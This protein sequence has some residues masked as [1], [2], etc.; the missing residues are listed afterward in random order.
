MT[1]TELAIK[2]PTLI[3]VFFLALGVVGIFGY[4]QLRYELLPKINIPWVNIQTVYPGASPSE[5]ENS[6]TRKI[7]DAV[8][9]IEKIT[10]IYATS[11]EGL[12]IVS[13]EFSRAA[14]I[15]VA[16]SE[17]Q[18]KVNA[19]TMF[20]PRDARTPIVQKFSLEEA[21]TLRLGVTSNMLPREFY[22][23]LTDQI[24]PTFSKIAGVG[25]VSLIGVDIR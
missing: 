15:D 13:I 20:L 21:P 8:S 22:Q 1:V 10:N 18:R 23:F 2:R 12:S 4:Y 19:A 24:Q 25:Q 14:E 16:V 3:V 17:V 5:V 7:E 6:V 11:Y 9:T